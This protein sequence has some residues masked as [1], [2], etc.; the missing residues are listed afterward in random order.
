M[1]A[2]EMTSK[3]VM[4]AKKTATLNQIERGVAAAFERLATDSELKS[5]GNRHNGHVAVVE[6]DP[7]V[8]EAVIVKEV[9]KAAPAALVLQDYL[10]LPA[11]NSPIFCDN[12]R[13]DTYEWH[14]QD[15]FNRAHKWYLATLDPANGDL[16]DRFFTPAI[17]ELYRKDCELWAYDRAVVASHANNM[18][19]PIRRDEI[20]QQIVRGPSRFILQML[21]CE[22]SAVQGG[23]PFWA[24]DNVTAVLETGRPDSFLI[25][26]Y[27]EARSRRNDDPII[28]AKYGPW[29]VEVAR[30]E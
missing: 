23:I 19:D 14:N 27:V 2:S 22:W 11:K 30:W 29:V 16:R 20:P 5:L 13:L 4:Q 12:R 26:E 8:V 9:V 3:E 6:P 10:P 7:E 15:N 24:V 25:A 1:G 21:K 18:P 17:L 28:Y